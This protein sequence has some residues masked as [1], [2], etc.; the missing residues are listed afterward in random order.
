M[1]NIFL[2]CLLFLQLFFTE[3]LRN[4][5]F[6]TYNFSLIFILFISKTII[7][8]L[9]F[10]E[11]I[12]RIQKFFSTEFRK[13]IDNS[14]RKFV[15]QLSLVV[16]SIPLPIMIHGIT[17]GRYNFKVINHEIKFK[18]PPKIL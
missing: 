10:F 17:R 1:T 12:F 2:Y 6:L 4:S 11:D 9:L 18:K 5:K 7:L 15:S 14:R 13:K 16:A 3:D 8:T